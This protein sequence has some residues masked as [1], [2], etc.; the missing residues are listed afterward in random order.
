M[1]QSTV[2]IKTFTCKISDPFDN[3]PAAIVAIDGFVEKTERVGLAIESLNKYDI[4]ENK[5]GLTY[6]A[7]IWNSQ[8]AKAAGKISRELLTEKE[9]GSLTSVFK[10]DLEHAES[11]QIMASN[12]SQDDKVFTIIQKDL[13]RRNR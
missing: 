10:A 6:T 13:I 7:S 5:G 3:Y 4:N 8:A 2:A 11:V 9:D 1:T 12:L